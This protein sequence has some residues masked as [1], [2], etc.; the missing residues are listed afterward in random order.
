MKCSQK[1][2]LL[3]VPGGNT[4]L[5]MINTTRESSSLR[6]CPG[7]YASLNYPAVLKKAL[8]GTPYMKVAINSPLSVLNGQG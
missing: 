4:G 6:A 2:F 8:T 5:F 7:S 1:E 3:V